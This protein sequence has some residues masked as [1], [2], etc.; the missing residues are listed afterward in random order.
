MVVTRRKTLGGL[1]VVVAAGLIPRWAEATSARGLTL[2]ALSKRSQHIVVGTPLDSIARYETIAGQKRIVTE[3]RFGID[4]EVADAPG[5]SEILVR[6]LGGILDGVGELV[7]GE[8]QLVLN[9]RSVV[10]LHARADGVLWMQGMAQGHYPLRIESQRRL[11]R[12]SPNLPALT[13]R[14]DLAVT[15]LPG[16]ELVEA[17]RLI[18]E[19]RTR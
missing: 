9:E 18:K 3:T 14:Q 12:V 2:E 16:R 15:R 19:A 5:D 6:T 7:H 13:A 17:K 8:A 10:F 11:L 1:G 4:D